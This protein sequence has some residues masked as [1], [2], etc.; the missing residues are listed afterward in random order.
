MTARSFI[1]A[2]CVAFTIALWS[3]P[4][5]P[6]RAAAQDVGTDAQRESGKKL[7]DKYCSQCHGD[8]GDGEKD[9][10]HGDHTNCGDLPY[11]RNAK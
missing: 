1:A 2:A 8:K 11:L 3:A 7:Y 9:S 10:T 5:E 6:V 4:M